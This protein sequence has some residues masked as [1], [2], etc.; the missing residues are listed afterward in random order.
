MRDPTVVTI[1]IQDTN[2]PGPLPS[3]SFS[4]SSATTLQRGDMCMRLEVNCTSAANLIL[5]VPLRGDW[6]IV[7][8]VGTQTITLKDDDGTTTIGTVAA[9]RETTLFVYIDSSGNAQWPGGIE[10]RN[11]STGEAGPP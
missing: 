2:D 7:C 10:V 11:L 3:Q 8:N 4:M 1:P 9:S 5:P 6:L